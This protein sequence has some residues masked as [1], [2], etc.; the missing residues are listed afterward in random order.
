MN[1]DGFFFVLLF[2][3]IYFIDYVVKR[4]RD[5]HFLFFLFLDI[6]LCLLIDN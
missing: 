3:G 2:L 6:E 5:F 4:G 1:G